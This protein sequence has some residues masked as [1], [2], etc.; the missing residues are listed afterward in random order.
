MADASASPTVVEQVTKA[1]MAFIDFCKKYWFMGP[2]I[3]LVVMALGMALKPW[4]TSLM[5]THNADG[6]ATAAGNGD[7]LPSILKSFLRISG[8]LVPVGFV[9]LGAD[10]CYA[11]CAGH[12]P[13]AVQSS[14]GWLSQVWGFVATLFSAGIVFGISHLSAPDVLDGVTMPGQGKTLAYTPGAAQE[15]SLYMQTSTKNKTA[16]G[17]PLIGV[18]SIVAIDT[19]VEQVSTGSNPIVSQDLARL[20]DYLQISS[21]FHGTVLDKVTG[22]GPILENGIAFV[23]Q[24]FSRWGDAPTVTITVPSSDPND[25]TIT[26][27]FTFPWAQRTLGDPSAT[28]PWLLT[29]DNMRFQIGIAAS[30]ALAAVSTGANTKGASAVRLGTSYA[31]S[32]LWRQNY[33]PYARLDTP[34]SGED[35]L[36]FQNFGGTGPAAS[37]PIDMILGLA[38]LSSLA[39][40]PGNLTFDTLTNIIGPDFG[41]D[42]VKAIDMLVL[43]RR[44]AQAV[45]RIGSND[46]ANDGNYVQGTP[47]NGAALDKL[48]M[49]WLRQPSLDMVPNNLPKFTPDTKPKMR[50]VFSVPRT[51]PDAFLTLSLREL[52]AA[53]MAQQVTLSGGMMP[54]AYR[55]AKH[56]KV[57][58][59]TIAVT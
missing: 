14:H 1:P 20:L 22:T 58:S 34:A 33:L 53:K 2:I 24:G 55:T 54:A 15:L 13:C 36:I 48:L 26:K 32:P 47:N 59:K 52:S 40:L 56:F 10:Y 6:T 46:Y 12:V 51:G 31:I 5:T 9:L 35:G 43:A 41:L 4:F 17:Q 19:T 50:G 28:C 23:G 16:G 42:D 57:P 45:G 44:Q 21:L 7:K 18:D 11:A 38:W 27:F 8:F 49:L 30:T 3:V 29:L 25:Q 39:G 37:K